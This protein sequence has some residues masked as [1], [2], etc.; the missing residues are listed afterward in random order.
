MRDL[1]TEGDKVFG[2]LLEVAIVLDLLLH[3]LG[4]GGGNPFGAFFALEEAPEDKVRAEL[5]DLAFLALLEELFTQGPSAQVVDLLHLN[6][7]PV[8]FRAKLIEC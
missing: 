5:H 8:P 3:L 1:I 2:Q 4:L 7:N 6:Q